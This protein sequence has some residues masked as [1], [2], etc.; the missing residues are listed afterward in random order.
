MLYQQ[1]VHLQGHHHSPIILNFIN[2]FTLDYL[3][4]GFLSHFVAIIFIHLAIAHVNIHLWINQYSLFI[5]IDKTALEINYC[6]LIFNI[7]KS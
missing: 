5:L 7:N 1:L 2:L 6:F 3:L 4:I